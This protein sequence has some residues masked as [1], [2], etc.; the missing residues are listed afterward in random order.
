[1][2]YCLALFTRESCYRRVT[3]VCARNILPTREKHYGEKRQCYAVI[4][5]YERC[6][7]NSWGYAQHSVTRKNARDDTTATEC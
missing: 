3:N 7:N 4:I 2:R 1:M 5:I 6:C